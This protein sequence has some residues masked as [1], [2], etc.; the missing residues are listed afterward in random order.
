VVACLALAGD[1]PLVL[2]RAGLGDLAMAACLTPAE[3]LPL[4]GV[5]VVVA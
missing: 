1:L 4:A 2:R 5:L 3:D